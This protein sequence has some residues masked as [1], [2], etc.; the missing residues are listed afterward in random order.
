MSMQP[1][2]RARL[3]PLPGQ[4]RDMA[5]CGRCGQALW[6][7]ENACLMEQYTFGWRYDRETETWSPTQ[8]H[9]ANREP[10]KQRI[11]TGTETP[12]DREL[13]RAAHGHVGRRHGK[14]DLRWLH[15]GE[16]TAALRLP[17]NVICTRCGESNVVAVPDASSQD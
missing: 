6:V 8:K 15:S 17:T 16:R 1:K 7:V 3:I 4:F 11:L 5:R 10:A 14:L 9:L 12:T 13:L 2:T